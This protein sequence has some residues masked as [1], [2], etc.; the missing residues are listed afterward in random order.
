[1]KN[2]IK[3]SASGIQVHIEFDLDSILTN[4]TLTRSLIELGIKGI[5]YG[6]AQKDHLIQHAH[7]GVIAEGAK[8]S[9]SKL[10]DEE[11]RTSFSLEELL[12]LSSDRSGGVTA[13]YC[14]DAKAALGAIGFLV[15]FADVKENGSK[16]KQAEALMIEDDSVLDKLAKCHTKWGAPECFTL[17]YEDE[18][19]SVAQVARLLRWKDDKAKAEKRN[20][21]LDG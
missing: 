14:D 8:K 18:T 19:N 3:T 2:T 13:E 16:A 7:A 21:L 6:G 1:M 15:S 17:T 9:L 10:D 11:H 5:S 4:T 20:D 12:G